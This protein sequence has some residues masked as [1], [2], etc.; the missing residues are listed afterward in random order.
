[1]TRFEG[2]V[3]IDGVI[4]RWVTEDGSRYQVPQL[5]IV[6]GQHIELECES[7]TL[8]CIIEPVLQPVPGKHTF[9]PWSLRV[10]TSQGDG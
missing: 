1:M 2:E 9:Y 8:A 10:K 6:K 4:T 5:V 3:P 7:Q